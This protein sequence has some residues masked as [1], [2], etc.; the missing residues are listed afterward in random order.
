MEKLIC[1]CC[2][3]ELTIELEIEGG[4]CC[5]QEYCYCSYPT[6]VAFARHFSKLP[7]TGGCDFNRKVLHFKDRWGSVKSEPFVRGEDEISTMIKSE[8]WTFQ[9]VL[10]FLHERWQKKVKK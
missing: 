4:G 7:K 1:P 3:E 9:H 10:N 2:N 5:N 6:L 8:D